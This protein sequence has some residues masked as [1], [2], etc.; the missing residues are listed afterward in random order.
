MDSLL[1]DGE[2]RVSE[3]AEVIPTEDVVKLEK[4]LPRRSEAD[5]KG[6]EKRLDRQMDKTLYLVV[7]GK[8]GWEFPADELKNENLHEVSNLAPFSSSMKHI[9]TNDYV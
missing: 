2:V 6:D 7:K 1:K 4:P 9:N 3:D 8:N 5:E